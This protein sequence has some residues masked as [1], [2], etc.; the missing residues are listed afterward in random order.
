MSREN[1][2]KIE[3]IEKAPITDND[4]F[5]GGVCIPTYFIKDGKEYFA[6]NR[7]LNDDC[8]YK[9][10]EERW[11]KEIIRAGG[12]YIRYNSQYEDPLDMLAE[13]VENR[14]HFVNIDGVIIDD[15]GDVVFSGNCEEVSAAFHYRLYGGELIRTIKEIVDLLENEKMR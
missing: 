3:F 1:E 5:V 7:F 6:F 8:F 13:I 10:Q 11:K 15:G 4:P 14:H 2:I 9:T 12:A